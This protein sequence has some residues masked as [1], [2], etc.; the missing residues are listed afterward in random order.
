VLELAIVTEQ[1]VS[2]VNAFINACCLTEL[3]EVH[4]L[5]G[6][7]R[8]AGAARSSRYAGIFGAIR[9]VLRFG[10]PS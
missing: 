5:E 8:P 2:A 9:S 1:P 7:A 3:L 10:G 6:S 4:A